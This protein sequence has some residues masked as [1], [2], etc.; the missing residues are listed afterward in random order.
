MQR[1]LKPVWI[2]EVMFEEG[3]RIGEMMG[4]IS[5]SH[6]FVLG[7]LCAIILFCQ[8]PFTMCVLLTLF[9]NEGISLVLKRVFNCERPP[10]SLHNGKGFPSSHTQFWSCFL[11]LLQYYINSQKRLTQRAKNLFLCAN[12]FVLIL[13]NY[14]RW[15]LNDHYMY[16]LLAGDICGVLIGW[17][18]LYSK[19]L[20]VEWLGK[21]KCF[22]FNSMKSVGLLTNKEN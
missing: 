5:I 10:L 20:V 3:D 2:A 21:A 19:N 8:D 9:V 12:C 16:Q 1:N 6:L 17:V 14:S 22:V 15:Y 18:A 4:Y 7:G 13:V 11:L